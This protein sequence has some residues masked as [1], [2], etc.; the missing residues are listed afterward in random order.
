[1]ERIGE[2]ITSSV[3]AVIG[4]DVPLYYCEAESDTL[5]YVL[6]DYRAARQYIKSGPELFSGNLQTV[7]V[8]ETYDT[9][10]RLQESILGALESLTLGADNMTCSLMQAEDSCAEGVW[11]CTLDL[12]FRASFDVISDTE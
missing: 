9:M 3:T 8:A 1:M 11:I 6:Y 2:I 10:R 7:V 5:P 4:S 12:A